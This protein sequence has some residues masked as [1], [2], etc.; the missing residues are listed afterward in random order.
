M[1]LDELNKLDLDGHERFLAKHSK[2]LHQSNALIVSAKQV[3]RIQ[4]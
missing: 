3:Q 1:E 4:R 2:A